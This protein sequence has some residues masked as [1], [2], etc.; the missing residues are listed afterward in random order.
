MYAGSL[1]GIIQETQLCV[2]MNNLWQYSLCLSMK[3]L[4]IFNEN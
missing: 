1:I 3:H 2:E 4:L